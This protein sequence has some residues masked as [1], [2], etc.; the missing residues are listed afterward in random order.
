L[1]HEWFLACAKAFCPPGKLAVI[2]VKTDGEITAI[3]PLT[4]MERG[5]IEVI[6]L[7]GGSF[8]NEPSGLIYK[9]EESLEELVEAILRLRK[10]MLL[11]RLSPE[12]PELASLKGLSNK[13]I[14]YTIRDTSGTPWLPTNTSWSQFEAGISASRRASLRRAKRRAEE[15]GSVS[16]EIL[17][18]HPGKLGT[19][20]EEILRV[21]A[22]GWKGRDKTAILSDERIRR[23]FNHYSVE[24]ARLGILRF[25]F[26]KIDSKVVAVQ[27]AIEHSNRFWVLKIGYDEG[28]ARCSPGMLLMHETIRYAFERGLE[29]YEFLGSDQ[30]WLH[31]WARGVRR[32]VSYRG[33]PFSLGSVLG[34]GM[35]VSQYLAYKVLALADR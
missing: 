26:M 10:P 11:S 21:E 22:A 20:L 1:R 33:Y 3:A 35:D 28:W 6:E 5:G 8:L 25:C 18:P 17:S 2:T 9:D 31:I 15:A 34:L 24:A 19:L 23:F 16:F 29:S 7:L 13:R 27:I 30:P 12:T 4:L 14:M 32:C